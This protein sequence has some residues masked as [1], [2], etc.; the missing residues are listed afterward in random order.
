M[1]RILGLAALLGHTLG[2]ATGITAYGFRSQRPS[3]NPFA[4]RGMAPEVGRYWHQGIVNA[5]AIQKQLIVSAHAKRQRRA[6]KLQR[7][8]AA[9]TN[10][11]WAHG[12]GKRGVH[13]SPVPQLSAR[14]NPFYVAK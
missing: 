14:L 3:A 9:S 6:E 12:I 1:K 11:N 2:A 10:G 13:L 7:D 8:M 5:D 4:Y